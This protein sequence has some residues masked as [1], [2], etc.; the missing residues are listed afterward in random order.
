MNFSQTQS[1]TWKSCRFVQPLA[2]TSINATQQKIY[3]IVEFFVVLF[4][5]MIVLFWELRFV[6]GDAILQ[7]KMIRQ[8]SVCK[9][10][11]SL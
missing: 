9:V 10:F 4:K 6:D 3:K 11:F 5:I 2:W 7:F 1:N 8:F